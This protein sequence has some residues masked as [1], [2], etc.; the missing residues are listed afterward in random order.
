MFFQSL[1]YLSFIF[2]KWPSVGRQV[3]I[4]YSKISNAKYSGKKVCNNCNN[5]NMIIISDLSYNN[6]VSFLLH[7]V[8]FSHH[9]TKMALFTTLRSICNKESNFLFI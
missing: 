9:V 1:I 8:T 7:F 3:V 5:C 2:C 4:F 6:L